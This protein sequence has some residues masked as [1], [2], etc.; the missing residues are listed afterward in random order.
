[1]YYVLLGYGV[2]LAH[3]GR[4]ILLGWQIGPLILEV[5]QPV[6]EQVFVQ[7]NRACSS[8]DTMGLRESSEEK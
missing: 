1:M 7:T 5:K 4:Q 6:D 3:Q 8:K 2:L